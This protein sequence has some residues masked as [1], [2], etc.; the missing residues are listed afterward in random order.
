MQPLR[1][2]EMSRFL[3]LNK[4]YFCSLFKK[5]TGINYSQFV[6]EV[7]IEKSKDLLSNTKLSVLDIALSV[8]Y[9]NSNYYNM[10]FKRQTGTTPFQY[11]KKAV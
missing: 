10:T 7:R 1:L 8:G 11:R 6:N 5:E 3:N 4:S 9:N 2:D